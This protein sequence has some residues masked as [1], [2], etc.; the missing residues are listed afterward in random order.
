MMTPASHHTST[1]ELAEI[2]RQIRPGL[3][4]LNHVLFWGATE[5]EL[6]AE[7]AQGY[8]GKVVIGADLEVFS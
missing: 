2:A 5:A 4:V 7:I 8:H 1:T 6:L 3:L